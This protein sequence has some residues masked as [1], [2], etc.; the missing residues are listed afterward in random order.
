MKSADT[1]R[2]VK[3]G[4]G[5]YSGAQA[6]DQAEIARQWAAKAHASGDYHARAQGAGGAGQGIGLTGGFGGARSA[7][8]VG[9]ANL[10]GA[11]GAGSAIAGVGQ[12]GPSAGPRA[13]NLGGG[14]APDGSNSG[15]SSSGQSN[16][17]L[18]GQ[19][20]GQGGYN[21]PKGLVKPK[22]AGPDDLTK[23]G[24]FDNNKMITA[25]LKWFANHPEY[26]AQK[27]SIENFIGNG[28]SAW[29]ACWMANAYNVCSQACNDPTTTGVCSSV[30]S[31]YASCMEDGNRSAVGCVTEC[32]G[33]SGCSINDQTYQA[34]CQWAQQNEGK[35]PDCNTA[36][37]NWPAACKNAAL[38]QGQCDTNYAW[39]PPQT[40]ADGS[41]YQPMGSLEGSVPPTQIAGPTT[42]GNTTGT[43]A[44]PITSGCTD[45]DP[46]KCA[47]TQ[48]TG[49]CNPDI[50]CCI[51]TSGTG[52]G[53]GT[54]S[55]SGTGSGAG[56]GSPDVP[57]PQNAGV[58]DPYNWGDTA[59]IVVGCV[60]TY[61]NPVITGVSQRV[62]HEAAKIVDKAVVGGLQ[63]VGCKN[64]HWGWPPC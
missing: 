34:A 33:R 32:M 64:P 16:V 11:E 62:G 41:Q 29:G 22:S 55:G 5:N 23:D 53:T 59:G 58:S 61:C 45:P 50:A 6:V 43:S 1:G 2:V 7:G 25:L 15:G 39:G 36:Q 27:A 51:D 52:T 37:N 48:A 4:L 24:K 57:N 9:G 42:T 10:Y 14:G 40:L 31:Q 56:S 21:V 44:A 35:P 17:G 28:E 54:G 49:G 60:A 63:A 46:I 38:A 12:S 20:A 30:P 8:P 18:G 3:A 47:F 26:A 13:A 19:D